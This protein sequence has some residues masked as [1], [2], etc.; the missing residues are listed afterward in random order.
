MR[1]VGGRLGGRRINPPTNKWPTRP[2]TD[3]AREAL[4]NIL[5]G[6]IDWPSISMLDL[7]GG[8]GM[9]TLEAMSR[10]CSD[11]TYVD[12]HRPCVHWLKQISKDLGVEAG[13]TIL[14][15]D[16]KK[17]IVSQKR[18]SNSYDLLFADPPYDW[19]E[20]HNLADLIFGADLVSKSGLLVIEHS[21]K[22]DLSHHVRWS[23]D[24]KYGS[25]TFSFFT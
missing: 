16:V 12:R 8:T 22:T 4:F 14:P 9:I 23:E 1:I 19:R 11:V 25:S 2:T 20:M 7:F 3:F 24:R 15:L 10:G 13:L 6:K 5:E 18:R 17:F 21:S